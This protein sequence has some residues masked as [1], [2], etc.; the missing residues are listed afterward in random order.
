MVPTIKSIVSTIGQKCRRCYSCVRE[1]PTSAIRVEFG[2]AVVI[3]DRCISCGHC[4]K[5]CSQHAKNIDS[6]LD[7]VINEYLPN[8]N[9][10]AIVAPAF[11]ASFPGQFKKIPT[12][13]RELGF[14]YVIETAFGADLIS[15]V[16]KQYFENNKQ[17]TIISSPCPAVYNYIEK[18]YVE[19]VP[20]L[21]PIVSPMI[22]IGRYLK[23]NIPENKIVFIGPCVA[24]KH[25]YEDPAVAGVIDAVLTF[26]ELKKIIKLNEIDLGALTDSGFDPPYANMGK[27]YPLAGGLL[28]TADIRSDLLAKE[29]IVVEGKE[30]SK[31]IIGDISNGKIK[32]KF[33]DILF[34]EGCINGPAIESEL[35]YY[36]RREYIIDYIDQNSNNVDKNVWKSTIYNSRNLNLSREFT[37][38]NKRRPMP[39]EEQI[40]AILSKTNKFVKED[41]LN[42][43][44]CGYPSCREYAVA[45]GKG[46]AEEEMCLPFL[47]DKLEQAYA[48]LKETQEHLHS[49]EK[50]ASIGQLAA[51]VAHE[52]NNPLGTILLYSSML[53]RDL[54]NSELCSQKS[55]DLALIIDEA[56]RCKNIVSNLLNFARQGKLQ[57]SSVSVSEIISEIIRTV[58]NLKGED[59]TIIFNDLTDNQTFSGDRDQIKQ[60]FINLINNARES[61]EHREKK[62]L[63]IIAG[64]SEEFIN[65][66]VIDTGCGISEENYKKLF[67]PFFTTKKIGKGTGLGLAIAYGIIKMHKGD[68]HISSETNKGTTV[69]VK[70]P[71]KLQIHNSFMN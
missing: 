49:A 16:Y 34:C 68:I 58:N 28:K 38:Q 70:L 36:S 56:K 17:K 43:R 55:E 44:A 53:K 18:Y 22:A 66:Q 64:R 59:E 47:I 52:L 65:I 23:E 2:Q 24:K 1:C 39:S 45:I 33:V 63:T 60:V 25:E 71:I 69:V 61:M 21:A 15:P 54:A 19:L 3:V 46:L 32:S 35:N 40:I 42:C 51:G 31:E 57:I 27:S 41:E 37:P 62:T 29:V 4:V 13:L 26:T 10:I 8:G 48:E 6:E 50:L 9:I 12:V 7:K 67:T 11:A 5:V 14:K 20:N 30:K